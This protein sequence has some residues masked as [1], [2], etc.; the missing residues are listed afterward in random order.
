MS[1]NETMNIQREEEEYT[2]KDNCVVERKEKGK[3][4]ETEKGKEMEKGKTVNTLHV[5][6]LINNFVE[7]LSN[8]FG[9]KQKGLLLYKRL[10]EKTGL[11]HDKPIQ[12]HVDAFRL[13]CF[14][15][16]ES[17]FQMDY[18][19]MKEENISYSENVAIN[20]KTILK[21]SDPTTSRIIWKHLLTFSA[22]LDPENNTK[23]I[24][25]KAQ[26]DDESNVETSDEQELIDSL[27]KKVELSVDQEEM[28]ENPLIV[29]GKLLSS[30]VLTDTF[31]NMQK[32]LKNGTLDMSKLMASAQSK[33]S[34]LSKDGNAGAMPDI[35][36]L[37]SMMTMMNAGGGMP[38]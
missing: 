14:D 6:K 32:G 22:F 35:S 21:M 2:E 36:T 37:M 20:M 11:I 25:L 7:E 18:S 8:V 28:K 3:E 24:L 38:V 33:M 9:T 17:I 10:L 16:R 1:N 29:V 27:I 12:K 15:N 5:F 26:K 31:A 30:G 19:I 34:S 13:F 4:M 23:S